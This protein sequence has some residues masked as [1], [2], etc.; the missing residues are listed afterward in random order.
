MTT[1]EAHKAIL[2]IF[3]SCVPDGK[4]H[5]AS[6]NNQPYENDEDIGW[7]RCCQQT[8]ENFEKL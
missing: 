6:E 2:A 3:K 4:R 1:E 8:L 5:F 7:N